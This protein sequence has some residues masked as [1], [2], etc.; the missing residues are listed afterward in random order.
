MG[1]VC[2][3]SSAGF[4]DAGFLWDVCRRAAPRY[5]HLPEGLPYLKKRLELNGDMRLYASELE[6]LQEHAASF[7]GSFSF[8]IEYYYVAWTNVLNNNA[9]TVY[10]NETYE[11][12]LPVCQDEVE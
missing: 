10:D 11:M 2:L 7:P 3:K 8:D 9:V 12:A 1:N 5:P 6:L 4:R